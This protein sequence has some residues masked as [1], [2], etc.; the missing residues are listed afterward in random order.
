MRQTY[1][2]ALQ[3]GADILTLA[4]GVYVY[5]TELTREHSLGLKV[6]KQH[7]NDEH[8]DAS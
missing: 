3:H 8:S 2:H 5:L 6:K 7:I 1:Q 4:R